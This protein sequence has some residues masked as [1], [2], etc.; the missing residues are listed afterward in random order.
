MPRGSHR[1]KKKKSPM[2]RKPRKFVMRTKEGFKTMNPTL[3]QKRKTKYI[4][5]YPRT[6]EHY[7]PPGGSFLDPFGFRGNP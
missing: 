1:R 5:Y 3:S 6:G 7:I 2:Y 4:R